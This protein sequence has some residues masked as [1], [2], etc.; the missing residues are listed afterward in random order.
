MNRSLLLQERERQAMTRNP[1]RRTS[2][3]VLVVFALALVALIGMTGLLLDG[4]AVFAQQ[5]V[6]QNGAD[7]AATAGALVVAENLGTATRTGA[8]VYG[9]IQ[10][11]ATTSGLE[12]WTAEYTDDFG[13]PIGQAVVD[14]GA[15]PS[16]AEGVRVRG[17][18]TVGA[19]FSRVLGVNQLQAGADATVV[20]GNLST[21]CV[22]SEDGCALLPLTFPVKVPSCDGSG[23]FTDID[24]WIG[25]PPEG[26]VVDG[27]WPIVGMED[28]PTTADPDGNPATKAILPL[29]RG[30]AGSSGAFG[31]L[32][33][34]GG[35]NLA[36]EIEG[37]LNT[38]FNVPDWYKV[39]TGTPNSVEDEIEL[40]L[41]QPVLIPLHNGVC[42]DDPGDT[43][44]CDVP[45]PD[46]AGNNT[47]YYVVAMGVFYI[48]NVYVQG[49]NVDE[50]TTEPGEPLI[51][52]TTG[53][54]FYGC[55]KGWFVNWITSGPIVPGA[56][57]GTDRNGPIGIQLIR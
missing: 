18:R 21:E 30:S 44:V 24:Y 16:G 13:A 15:I 55:L 23:E 56:E 33:L 48:D 22:Q 51:E 31:F 41:H 47:W 38:T 27:Y 5:R 8:D 14:S 1:S 11:V 7:G 52:F 17:S 36:E 57:D 3:Q 53:G 35:M 45:G 39:Q 37:P 50:C 19:T 29:C 26:T 6:A 28:L 9:A 43:E 20:A 10:G 34:V 42:Q 4:G 12:G 2:G 32:D 54:G 46:P 40:W 49:S 25:A